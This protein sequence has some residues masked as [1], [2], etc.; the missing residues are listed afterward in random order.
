MTM[1]GRGVL[2]T[3]TEAPPDGEADF[4]E[5]YN[6]E[7]LDERVLMPGFRRARRYRAVH[8]R[9]FYFASYE[10]GEVADLAAPDYLARLADQ[11]PWS[12][13]VMAG[14]QYFHRLTCEVT[15]DQSRG[16]GGALTVLRGV[17]APADASKFRDWLSQ[18]EFPNVT[19]RAGMLGATLLEN[20]LETANAPAEKFGVKGFPIV[21]DQEWAIMLDGADT[22]STH[23]A[24]LALQDALSGQSIHFIDPLQQAT[25]QLL[26]GNSREDLEQGSRET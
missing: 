21:S 16:I 2:L 20:H 17:P 19:S 8:G 13:N 18:S 4:N 23:H 5:W 12:K 9:P 26:Y 25:Y 1:L 11:S 3:L 14:L 15:V 6:R 24:G 7:H 22:E 10:T